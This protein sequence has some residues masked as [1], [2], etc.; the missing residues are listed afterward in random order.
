MGQ[1][2]KKKNMLKN[3]GKLSRRI[4]E[5][6]STV[7][8]L[9]ISLMNERARS[10]ALENSKEDLRRRLQY[11]STM[12]VYHPLTAG[13][14][15]PVKELEVKSIT[16]KPIPYGMACQIKE[17]QLDE[18]VKE[19]EKELAREIAEGLLK[20]GL[21]QIIIKRAEETGGP[22]G[23]DPD[24]RGK[25][26]IGVKL[27]VV[28]WETM[29]IYSREIKQLKTLALSGTENYAE[30]CASMSAEKRQR[31]LEGNWEE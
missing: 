16:F 12:P 31:W 30:M 19:K 8:A 23:W 13:G 10:G 17:Y 1:R 28:P 21:C 27:Y 15:L 22:F 14:R 24:I 7:A 11:L 9:N 26:T 20:S 18:L 25:A 6:E 2:P 4:R 3:N 5:L 29:Q